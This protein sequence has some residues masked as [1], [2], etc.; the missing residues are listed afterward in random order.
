[1]FQQQKKNGK[2]SLDSHQNISPHRTF[3]KER[4]YLKSGSSFRFFIFNMII[5]NL[6]VC[7]WERGEK[8][9]VKLEKM[10]NNDQHLKIKLPNHLLYTTPYSSTK[11]YNSFYLNKLLKHQ[12]WYV[13]DLEVQKHL[14]SQKFFGTDLRGVLE[15]LYIWHKLSSLKC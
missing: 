9:A 14:R 5:V 4:N 11:G 1:M 6:C 8:A 3:R 15:A 13:H 7:V 12:Q 2:T 10:K